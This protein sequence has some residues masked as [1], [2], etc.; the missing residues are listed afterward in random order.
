MLTRYRIRN[1]HTIIEIDILAD[2]TPINYEVGG[3]DSSDK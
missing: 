2:A 1:H 3:R